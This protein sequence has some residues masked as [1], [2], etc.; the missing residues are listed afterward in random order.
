[1][2]A[3]MFTKVKLDKNAMRHID[4]GVLAKNNILYHPILLA[5]LEFF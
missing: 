2:Y 3:T 5:I 1:M 4:T